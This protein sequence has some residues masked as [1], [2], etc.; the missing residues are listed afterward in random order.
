M[1]LAQF[2]PKDLCSSTNN[3]IAEFLG[4]H[5]ELVLPG[6]SIAL[7]WEDEAHGSQPMV[8][9]DEDDTPPADLR[10]PAVECFASDSSKPPIP[11]QLEITAFIMSRWDLTFDFHHVKM[12]FDI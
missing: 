2:D 4:V 12:G 6:A 3:F 7:D 11:G 9:G 10:L 1:P 5:N 8:S